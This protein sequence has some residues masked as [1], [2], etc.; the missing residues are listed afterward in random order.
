MIKSVKYWF[1]GFRFA[2]D[3]FLIFILWAMTMALKKT[4][5]ELNEL[6]DG[7][8]YSGYRSKKVSTNSSHPKG[9]SV[10][11]SKPENPVGFC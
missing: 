5:D 2:S 1:G 11:Y 6:K 8:R 3:V 9:K 4:E 7:P 10:P